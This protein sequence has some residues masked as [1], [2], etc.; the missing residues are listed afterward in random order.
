[1]QLKP[2]AVSFIGLLG[3]RRAPAPCVRPEESAQ[4]RRAKRQRE[5]HPREQRVVQEKVLELE[6]VEGMTGDF[7]HLD[8]PKESDPKIEWVWTK[9]VAAAGTTERDQCLGNDENDRKNGE[10]PAAPC[11][12]DETDEPGRPQREKK[13]Y[14]RKGEVLKGEVLEDLGLPRNRRRRSN[15][16]G[17][18]RD[19]DQPFTDETD[20]CGYQAKLDEPNRDP[21]TVHTLNLLLPAA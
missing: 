18:P 19:L 3:S 21:R 20:G 6:G 2:A 16:C 1:V 7:D 15:D 4:T 5:Q 12:P 9:Q 11:R 14:N 10:V 17:Q 13:A 8:G